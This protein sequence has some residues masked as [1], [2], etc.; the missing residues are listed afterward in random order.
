MPDFISRIRE[1]GRWARRFLP[2]YDPLRRAEVSYIV[3]IVSM[4]LIGG[5]VGV[6]Y[7]ASL[8]LFQVIYFA[9]SANILEIAEDLTWPWRLAAPAAGAFIAA[10]IVRLG[11][12]DTEGEGMSEILEAVVIKEKFLRV[13]RALWKGL[14]SLVAIG[15]GGSLGREGPITNISAAIGGRISELLH[16]SPERRRILIGCGVA[17]G[18]AAAYNAPIGSSLFVMEVI[19]GNFAMDIF[20]PLV[21]ASVVSTLVSRG[22]AGGAIYQVPEI[23]MVSTWEFLPYVLLGIGCAVVGR[24]FI[25][26][27]AATQWIFS[28]IPLPPYGRAALGGLGVGAIAIW[29]PH[30]MGNGYEGVNLALNGALPLK[31]LAF[32]LAAKLLA[33]GLSIGSGSSGGVFTPALFLGAMLGALTGDAAHSL[34]P[35][36]TAPPAAYALVGMSGVLAATTH[37]PIMST[38]MV[39]EMSL[40]YNLILPVMLCSGIAALL[41]RALK[42]ESIYTERLRQRG[43]DIDLA[44]EETALQSIRVEDV[45]WTNPPTVTPQTSLRRLVDSFLH[46]RGGG[47]LHVV[48]DHGSYHGMIDVHALLTAAEQKE[49]GDLLI[50]GD[51]ARQIPHVGAG[52]PVSNVT[53]KFWFQEHGEVPVISGGPEEKFL[54]VVTRRDILRAFD[55]EVLQ[56]KLLTARYAPGQSGA[57]HRRSMVDLPAEF[58][59]EEIPVPFTLIGRTLSDLDLPHNYLLTAL[60]LKPAGD[61]Q[62]EVIPPPVGVALREGDRLVL[63][64]RRPDLARFARG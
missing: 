20:G 55:R 54:G 15:S 60:S 9:S 7:R 32:A 59:I 34:W 31:L 50:A 52:E 24:L 1:W 17:S 58:A 28:R 37:A 41:S 16:V 18:M 26:T 49:L 2:A 10:L 43:V 62:P 53:E 25:G 22:I 3:L 29:V 63:V 6:L 48:D 45:M 5:L 13:R 27:L 12:K 47:S 51:L 56:R 19:I 46:M 35:G 4:G 21:V 14:S 38:L 44:I 33:T 11:L 57:G 8:T 61:G 23:S 30:V 64:G 39:F 36:A 42:R 40:N